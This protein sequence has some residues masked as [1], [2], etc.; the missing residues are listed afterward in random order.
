LLNGGRL[1][2]ESIAEQGH[3]FDILFKLFDQVEV[4]AI[5]KFKQYLNVRCSCC[6][7]TRSQDSL[8]WQ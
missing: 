4:K 5:N 2:L 8:P 7:P 1:G 3:N 6:C